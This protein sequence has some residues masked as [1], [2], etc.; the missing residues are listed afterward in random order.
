MGRIEVHIL[1]T[2]KVCV[3]P[4]LPFG[5]DC[6]LLKAAGIGT[7]ARDRLWLPVSCY[8]I[9]HPRGLLLFDCGWSR[10][11]SPQGEFDRRAQIAA[12]GSVPLYFT[13]Q[14]EVALGCTVGEQLRGRGIEP[15][16]L[17]YVLLSHL[18][19]DHANGLS[20]VAG[21]KHVLV[22]A[23]ELACATGPDIVKRIRFNPRW[24]QDVELEPLIWNGTEGPAGESF[25]LFGDG[26]VVMVNIP[27]HTD[28]LCALKLTGADG[29]YV[30]LFSDG[31]Y[32]AR[33]WQEMILPGISLDRTAQRRSLEW[34]REQSLNARCAES[35]ANHDPEIEPHTIV[36]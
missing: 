1:H 23:E 25:D 9:E 5:G 27:G 36:L 17:D 24:W 33:S 2:G 20:E 26:S 11:I 18:D 35:L 4:S 15:Q 14:G 8:L 29:R 32:A 16:D 19:C 12:L 21:A 10:A 3:S 6:G 31:G 22:A 13:N 28:G 30:L 34:I 7:P